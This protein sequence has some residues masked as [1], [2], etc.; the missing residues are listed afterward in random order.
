MGA[1]V[2]MLPSSIKPRIASFVDVLAKNLLVVAIELRDLFLGGIP[3]DALEKW[4][5]WWL[6]R[7]ELQAE[8]LLYFEPARLAVGAGPLVQGPEDGP[9]GPGGGGRPKL[10]SISGGSTAGTA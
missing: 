5:G 9:V 7:L 3:L 6:A 1:S 2:Q 10:R 8:R 4:T